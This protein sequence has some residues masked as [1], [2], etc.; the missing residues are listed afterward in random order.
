VGVAGVS[1]PRGAGAALDGIVDHYGFDDGAEALVP[2]P[3]PAPSETRPLAPP[4]VAPEA[5]SGG[6]S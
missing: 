3:V 1:P 5:P 2:P 4:T 6:Q